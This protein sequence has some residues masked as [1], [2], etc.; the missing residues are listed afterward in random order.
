MR[1]SDVGSTDYGPLRGARLKVLARD[2]TVVQL[3]IPAVH[4]AATSKGKFDDEQRT[5]STRKAWV[6]LHLR[7]GFYEIQQSF[8]K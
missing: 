3:T 4:S 8:Q 6:K 7:N 1:P 2:G 5:N